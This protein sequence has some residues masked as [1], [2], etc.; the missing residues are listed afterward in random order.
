MAKLFLRYRVQENVKCIWTTGKHSVEA[1]KWWHAPQMSIWNVGEETGNAWREHFSEFW[2]WSQSFRLTF[3]GNVH[4]WW[5]T[6]IFLRLSR[7]SYKKINTNQ[8]M[9]SWMWMSLSEDTLNSVKGFKTST[10]HSV[11]TALFYW[12]SLLRERWN[13]FINIWFCCL[14][15]FRIC[16]LNFISAQT[17]PPPLW[18]PPPH[19]PRLH[20]LHLIS[21]TPKHNYAACLHGPACCQIRLKP[22]AEEKKPLLHLHTPSFLPPASPQGSVIYRRISKVISWAVHIARCVCVCVSGRLTLLSCE[23]GR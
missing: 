8:V 2:S 16:Q 4:K 5:A 1:Q 14:S 9:S 20:T 15:F 3:G 13:V 17:P 21:S 19:P 6:K 10:Q 11:D 18:S 23:S 12:W 7:C 22:P